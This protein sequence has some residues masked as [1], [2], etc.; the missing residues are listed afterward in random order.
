MYF[1]LTFAELLLSPMG[2]S[3]VAKVAPPKVKGLMQGCWF[4]F[5]GLGNFLA[6][7]VGGF[8]AR[9][10]LWQTFLVLLV[11]CFLAAI[12]M[13]AATRAVERAAKLA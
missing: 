6:G 12:L 5:T 4:A 7:L 11:A 3:L 13:L 2:L 9:L 8:Y 10:E 1:T